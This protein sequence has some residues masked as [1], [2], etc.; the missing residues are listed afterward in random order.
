MFSVGS[1]TCERK[2]R[3]TWVD[4]AEGQ[5]LGRWVLLPVLSRRLVQHLQV[6]DA[7]VEAVARLAATHAEVPVRILEGAQTHGR[8][9]LSARF[10]HGFIS[11]WGQRAQSEALT[12]SLWQLNFELFRGKSNSK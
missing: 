4:G 3:L 2:R 7:S 12:L 5:V 9:V 1:S 11:N 8:V 6:A 10:T